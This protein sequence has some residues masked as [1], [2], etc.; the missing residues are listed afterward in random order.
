MIW[1]CSILSI[2]FGSLALSSYD[3]TWDR[4]TPDPLYAPG[5]KHN[6]KHRN[7]GY[8][9]GAIMGNGLLGTNFYKLEDNAYRLN[10][11]RSDI[12][13]VRDGEFSLYRAGRLPI[14]YFVLR[15]VGDVKK[16]QMRLHIGTAI[17]TGRFTTDAGAIHFKT[18]VHAT[19]DLIVFETKTFG[20][21]NNYF[22]DF[23]PQKAISPRILYFSGKA[24]GGKAM[25]D[26][27]YL[28]SD[29]LA[30][31]EP[32]RESVKD[33]N[34]LIQPL[35]ADTTFTKIN[36]Y[37]VV[38]WREV[39]HLGKR[40]V[41][42][43]VSQGE[44][45]EKTKS[46][47]VNDIISAFSTLGLEKRHK[48]WWHKFYSRTAQMS[49]PD[50]EIQR[51][52]WRQCY[53]FASTARPGKPIVDL[54]GVWPVCDTPWPA[55]WMNLNIQL[56]YS[57]QTKLGMGEYVQPLLDALWNNRDNLIRNVTDNPGQEDWTECMAIPRTCSYDMLS[58]L[59]PELA[60][61]NQYEAGNLIWTLF[62]CY[63][64]CDTYGDDVQMREKVFPLLKGAVNLFFRLR[65]V[66]SDG[67]YSLP[68]TAS[69]EYLE[70]KVEIGTNSNYD[71]ANLRWGLQTLIDLDNR[72][73]LGDSML[74]E[75]QDFLKHLVPF[76][77]SND[78]GFKVSDKHEFLLTNHRHY[79]HLFMIF[80]YH[81]LDWEDFENYTKMSLSME[82]WNG[83]EG[84][85]YTGKASM[86][87]SRADPGDGDK[88]LGLIKSFLTKYI[89]KNTLYN[90]SGPCME[91][92]MSAMC[93]LEDMYLQDWGSIIR[94]F[95]GCPDS[96]KE[97]SFKNMR[98][99]GAFIISAVRKN[100]ETV[101]VHIKSPKGGL[102]RIQ[103]RREA[104]VIEIP[105]SAGQEITL[106][107]RQIR[108]AQP[109]IGKGRVDFGTP[110]YHSS[111]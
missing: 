33:I 101:Y 10:V 65:T 61:R 5:V 66:N 67:S 106:T 34:L 36:S 90:E 46:K 7:D 38:G 21:E 57:W 102:C 54:Q 79:S 11:G 108:M 8:Y 41:I 64:L 71:L 77:Y 44:D 80:P 73:G 25:V 76:R 95:R 50:K 47:I 35:T 84:Y 49:F 52:Y 1:A 14:G 24:N 2:I 43:T 48:S 28:R 104:P 39:S 93:S 81:L 96:W 94:I 109:N 85:S 53:K 22:W 82:R 31:P 72:Y 87:C 45:L 51:F 40:R 29:G 100:G 4:L 16:E 42:A 68:P 103:L 74:P 27:D 12:T 98:A 9:D 6:H 110:S 62:Y 15:T 58:R 23:S 19:K 91:T 86:L 111:I 3:L 83:N 60:S 17:T 92:P 37:Y 30:N 89:R 55:I 105:M 75:W 32:W 20:K 13:E 63:Q 56:T 18:Y 59:D 78:T 26:P 88:A 107:P 70:G 97:C 69:P 99:A